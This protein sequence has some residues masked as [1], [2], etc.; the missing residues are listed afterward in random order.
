[1]LRAPSWPSSLAL[2]VVACGSG[3]SGGV[4]STA[5]TGKGGAGGTAPSCPTCPAPPPCRVAACVDGACTTT[6]SPA[7]AAC[8]DG[9]PCTGSGTCDAAGACKKG[10]PPRWAALVG[11]TPASQL[12]A[13]VALDDGFVRAL[14]NSAY[15]KDVGYGSLFVKTDLD[16]RLASSTS[17]DVE[18]SESFEALAAVPGPKPTWL[19]AGGVADAGG[20]SR[21]LVAKLDDAGAVV[22]SK[23]FDA[24]GPSGFQAVA[25]EPGG[26]AWLVGARDVSSSSSTAWAVRVD[27][28]GTKVAETAL[29][30][31]PNE[32]LRAV[33]PRAGGGVIVA[34]YSRTVPSEKYDAWI[35]FLDAKGTVEKR[36]TYVEQVTLSVSG[37]MAD[38]D[39]AI[40]LLDLASGG[41]TLELLRVDGAGGVTWK[42]TV[43]LPGSI[44]TPSRLARGPG[45]DVTVLSTTF[46]SGTVHRQN[47]FVRFDAS[48][49]VVATKDETPAGGA[50]RT[51]D[52]V[53]GQDGF[54]S[55]GS[56]W[57]PQSPAASTVLR[58]TVFRFDPWG[59]ASCTA[60][61]GCRGEDAASCGDGTS[62]T[63]DLCDAAT[64]CVHLADE[65]AS[66]P[67]GKCKAG[68]CLP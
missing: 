38:G 58:G 36:V 47:G 24:K 29:V 27:A 22:W 48:G 30:G 59:P 64:G 45:G 52:L 19:A 66:C 61:W 7:G 56:F 15:A 17:I 35:A 33:V 54:F 9:D 26:G 46:V 8:D 43:A 23:V 2:L 18:G 1:M 68:A 13:L 41:Q 12:R 60:A 11:D 32:A 51:Y 5:A 34:G 20:K 50:F 40:L 10:G 63:F 53:A 14:G 44:D 3:G 25:V 21:G 49:A 6:P 65:S 62:C 31:A 16:G 37:L 39:G 28:D 57:L 67:G 42:S 4:D 55:A